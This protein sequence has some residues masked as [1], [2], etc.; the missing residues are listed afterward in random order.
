[1]ENHKLVQLLINKNLTISFAES[2]TGGLLADAIISVENSS[3]VLN[4]SFV[5]YSEE[6]KIKR[7]GVKK[8]TLE[9]Y[10]VYSK[11]IADEMAR[12]VSNASSSDIGVGV[13]GVA[14]PSGGNDN[15]PVGCVYFSIYL[16]KDNKLYSFKE[17]FKKA[18]RNLIR[19]S[20]TSYIIDKIIEIL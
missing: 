8:E 1:M 9:K 19:Q 16:K 10:T 6:S 11:E 13:T 18:D 5:T 15:C 12:G 3:K 2:C 4:E 7:L 14:G 17:I 20:A